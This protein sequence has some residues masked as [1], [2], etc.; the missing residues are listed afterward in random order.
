M[1]AR[2]AAGGG[3]RA[4]LVLQRDPSQLLLS[5][6]ALNPNVLRTSSDL[7]CSR[8]CRAPFGGLKC[9]R[10][11]LVRVIADTVQLSNEG[12]EL[13]YGVSRSRAQSIDTGVVV[14]L[15]GALN[16]HVSSL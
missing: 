9:K 2:R 1:T 15:V 6:R 10:D 3:A 7:W 5:R 12:R 4:G 8:L 16:P 13:T 11:L 14:S